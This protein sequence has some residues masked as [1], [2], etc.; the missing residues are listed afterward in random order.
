M[1]LAI[2]EKQGLRTDQFVV[3]LQNDPLK[4]YIARGTQIL[5]VRAALRVGV[6]PVTWCAV[7]APHWYPMS[8]CV[9][10]INAAGAG[11]SMG[12]AIALGN[13]LEY[14]DYMVARGWT[15][16]QVAPLL[17]M[18]LDE[19][20]D[21]FMIIANLRATR[22]IWA[23][24][25]RERYG[26]SSPRS[27]ALKVTAYA[28]GQET[29]QEPLNN[30]T[31]LAF[32]TL[33]YV[34]GGV[35]FLYNA[36]YDEA[37]ATPTEEA[38]KLAIRAQQIIAH[39]QGLSDTVDPLAGSYFVESLT[40]QAEQQILNGLERVLRLG[41]AI[42]AMEKGFPQSVI[43]EGAV[44]RQREIDSGERVLVTVNRWP[45]RKELPTGAFKIDRG[46]A[47]HQRARLARV[48]AGRD[49]EQ[50]RAALARVRE[51]CQ[52]GENLVPPVLEAVKA[53][54]TIG[55]ICDVLRGVFGEYR[56]QTT[57]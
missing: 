33:A 12:T 11:S 27:Q 19:R 22:R 45:Q 20:H 49:G 56:A 23:R 36:S 28:H 35:N 5:P 3:D 7:H 14:L 38:V 17:S 51:A 6:D 29:L 53:Y 13:A 55:E 10:H 30:L 34:L 2:G 41:G 25:M 21:F 32:G 47:Q 44:R 54:A 48:K 42:A 4:E 43:A 57:V 39:E 31:R 18:F 16:D 24:L 9:N 46:T 52:S 37:M 8:V 40:N 26:A 15:I 1:P 50:V